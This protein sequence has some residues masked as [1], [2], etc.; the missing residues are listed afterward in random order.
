MKPA[1][2]AVAF[3]LAAALLNTGHAQQRYQSHGVAVRVDVLVTDGKKL[4]TSLNPEDFELR[5]QGVAQ[6]VT[7]VDVE[8]L[9]LNVI[10][11]VDTSDS[12]KGPRLAS[13]VAA[14]RALI[15]GL[16]DQ[17]RA[18]L[19]SFSSRVRLLSPLTPSRMQV[20]AA[21]D[22]MSASGTTSLRDAAFAA[23]SLREFASGRTLVL[24]FTDDADNASW[25]TEADVL[26]VAKHTDA[27]VYGVY[28]RR[29]KNI[30]ASGSFKDEHGFIISDPVEM[31]RTTAITLNT[32]AFLGELSQETGGRIIEAEGDA[33]L[34]GTFTSTLDEFRNRYVLSYTPTDVSSSGWHALDVRLKSKKGKVIARRGYFADGSPPAR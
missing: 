15:N 7:R 10:L 33:D 17:D 3:W 11:A 2:S 22:R 5:D 9:P 25:L 12:V 32:P 26:D 31:T 8:Q 16:H 27:V 6:T 20:L 13:L 1:R 21:L 4:V 30:A 19:L 23:L 14:A 28:V 29:T 18:A 24:M 34:A